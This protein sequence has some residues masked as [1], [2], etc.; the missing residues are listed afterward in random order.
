MT[1]AAA[2][3]RPE[4]SR[5]APL[6][7]LASNS[8]VYE[9][10]ANPAECAALARR[11]GLIAVERFAAT[12]RLT[13]SA[14]GVRLEAEIHA[15]TV[16]QCGVTLEPFPSALDDRF[17][18]LYRRAPPP[19][20]ALDPAAEDFETLVGEEIDIGEAVAQQ[21]SLALDPFP[22]APGA[23]AAIGGLDGPA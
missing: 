8:A 15:A 23:E 2:G 5:I 14:A 7:R 20:L 17:F 4:F 19:A 18:L 16:Q 22:R 10:V 13:G 3:E 1:G 12:V 21:L 9:I 6:A 11:F